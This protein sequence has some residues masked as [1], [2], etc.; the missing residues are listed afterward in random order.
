MPLMSDGGGSSVI[1]TADPSPPPAVP[2]ALPAAAE[3]PPGFAAEPEAA[4]ALAGVAL[5]FAGASGPCFPALG[6][7]LE[8]ALALGAFLSGV[9]GWAAT[10][11][12]VAMSPA[13]R[14]E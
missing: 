7:A 5:S 3:P 12:A 6:P 8:P 13:L 2:A 10:T 4:P 14:T 1:W 9:V 11:L